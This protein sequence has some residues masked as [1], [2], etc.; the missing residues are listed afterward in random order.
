[1]KQLQNLMIDIL[2]NGQERKTRSGVVQSVFRRDFTHDMRISFPATLGKK[3]AFNAMAGE[4]LWFSNGDTCLGS[5]RVYSGLSEGALTIWSKDCE[6]WNNTRRRGGHSPE[7]LGKLYGHQWRR[8]GADDHRHGDNGVDQ[9]QDLV[10]NMMTDPNS[11]YH[12]VQAYNPTD[13]DE[14]SAALPPCHTGFQ[15]YV[16]KTT[17]E[18]DLDWTQRS[19]DVF[20]G[21]PFN[22]ASYGW[23]MCV[24]GQ[25]TGLTPR[26]LYGSLKDTHLYMDHSEAITEYLSRTPSDEPCRLRMP[27]ITCLEDLKYLTAA[28]FSLENYNPQPAIKAPLSVG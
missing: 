18:F 10:T 13:V 21:L 9:L 20:L 19:V 2:T 17:G 6:R 4:G 22:I 7:D 8:F 16:D 3:L 14:E 28:D 25:I 11:R 5:L 23:L 27:H 12:I 1:M 24:L 26:F 15:I